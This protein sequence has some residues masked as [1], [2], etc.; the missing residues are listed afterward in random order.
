MASLR[1]ETII[2]APVEMCFDLSRD[3]DVHLRSMADTGERAVAGRTLGLIDLGETVTWEARHLGARRRF[4]SRITAFDRPRYFRDEMAQGDF[5]SFVHDHR[6]EA[7]AEGTRMIDELNFH[8]PYGLI[9]R[10]VDW[11]FLTGYLRRLLARRCEVI[12]KEA[13][14]RRSREG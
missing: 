2:A 11:I 8:S 10:F 7:C 6:F 12:K 14:S 9:G 1:I 3:I 4:T 5:C 13:E